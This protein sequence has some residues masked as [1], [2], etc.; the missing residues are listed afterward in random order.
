MARG[1]GS[2]DRLVVIGF[3]GKDQAKAWHD[4]PE[5]ESPKQTSAR[6]GNTSFLFIEGV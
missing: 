2:P 1:D 6:C 3:D 4:S 5:Y